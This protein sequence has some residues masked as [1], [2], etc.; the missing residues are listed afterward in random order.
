MNPMVKK[1]GKHDDE[2]LEAQRR[3]GLSNE[4]V[5]MAQA[6]GFPW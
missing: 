3:C 4:E 2:C 1:P 6:R 5:R